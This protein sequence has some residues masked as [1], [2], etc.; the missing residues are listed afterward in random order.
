MIIRALTWY[1]SACFFELHHIVP[2]TVLW[3]AA[4]ARKSLVKRPLLPDCALRAHGRV[5]LGWI[6][7]EE[8]AGDLGPS[9]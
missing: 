1:A 8:C 3:N 2:S 4:I 5:L 7:S 9:K 6:T